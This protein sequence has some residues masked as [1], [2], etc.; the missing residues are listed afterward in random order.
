MPGTEWSLQCVPQIDDAQASTHTLHTAI[1][2]IACSLG[3]ARGLC[4]CFRTH[5]GLYNSC[6]W[7]STGKFSHEALAQELQPGRN[8][9]RSQ[10]QTWTS[11]PKSVS[12]F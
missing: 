6:N 11:T 12:T 10:I 1:T 7:E 9:P 4:P 3:P 2:L 5:G 8:L